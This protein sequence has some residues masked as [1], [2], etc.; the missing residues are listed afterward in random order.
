M[1]T[2]SQS[3]ISTLDANLSHKQCFLCP[4][5]LPLEDMRTHVGRHIL[6]GNSNIRSPCG[7]CGRGSCNNTLGPPSK[8]GKE[9]FYNKVVSN[10]PYY[11]EVSR[12]IQKSS[13]RRPCTNYINKC[14]VCKADIWLYNIQ[15]H[16]E[17]MH[18]GFDI[19]QLDKEELKNMKKKQK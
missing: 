6:N 17:D 11:I 19:P 2:S 18:P 3:S 10:C 8:K 14:A 15:H 12:R 16:Y 9:Y 1:D 4:S 5:R 7:Y 13:P